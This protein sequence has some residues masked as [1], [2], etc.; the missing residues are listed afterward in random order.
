MST[1]LGQFSVLPK[2]KAETINRLTLSH[3]AGHMHDPA[4][5]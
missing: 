3:K 5:V 1:A 4:G 2:T